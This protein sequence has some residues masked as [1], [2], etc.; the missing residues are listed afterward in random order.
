MSKDTKKETLT[1]KRGNAKLEKSITIFSIPA[2]YSC[3]GAKQCL[4]MADPD[5]GKAKMGAHAEF[6]C[7]A[8]VAELRPNVRKSRW[9]NFE[10]LTRAK[11]TLKM[12]RLIMRSIPKNTQKLRIHESG[13]FFN[14]AYFD[15][16]LVVARRRPDIVFYAYTK[17]LKMWANRMLDVP[18][19]LRLTASHGGKYDRLIDDLQ[20]R[21]AE[22]VFHPEDAD[23]K[24]IDHDDSHAYADGDQSFA[25]L[26]HGSQPKDTPAAA[27]LRRLK[28]EN[29]EYSYSHAKN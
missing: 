25:L 23:G 12:A 20:L 29:I 18:N 27:A 21:S 14:Q 17:S 16:W 2:G 13:D 6:R 4:T 26:L 3:P 8:A 15:A 24:E 22:V 11:T 7:F 19:N 10:L 28:A 9:R 1:M 5:T